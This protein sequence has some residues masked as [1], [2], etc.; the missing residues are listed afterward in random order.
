MSDTRGP[1]K[2]RHHKWPLGCEKTA[3]RN[4]KRRGH[5]SVESRMLGPILLEAMRTASL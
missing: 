3:M 2:K 5:N 4:P 1:R